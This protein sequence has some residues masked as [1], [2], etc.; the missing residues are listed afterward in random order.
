MPTVPHQLHPRVSLGTF[1]SKGRVYM[2]ENSGALD[3]KAG[4]GTTP[5][6]TRNST[7]CFLV[8]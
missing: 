8:F 4:Q 7:L 1:S 2:S 5:L 6:L 3:A